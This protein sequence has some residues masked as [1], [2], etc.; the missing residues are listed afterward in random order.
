MTA[1]TPAKPTITA[2]QRRSPTRSPQHRI[3]KR[4]EEERRGEAD[5][6]RLRQ[7]QVAQGG[8]EQQSWRRGEE[9]RA[10]KVGAGNVAVQAG[11]HARHASERQETEALGE[12]AAPGDLDRAEVRGGKLD[13]R[14][15]VASSVIASAMSST[16]RRR[17]EIA[18]ALGGVT[19]GMPDISAGRSQLGR[20]R[21]P[22]GSTEVTAARSG[23]GIWQAIAM[24]RAGGDGAAACTVSQ[25]VAELAR[26]AGV[27]GAPC[28]GGSLR[29][30]LS[31]RD[32]GGASRAPTSGSG[33]AD[34]SASV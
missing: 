10:E 4:G 34:S 21:P 5:H 12:V 1:S 7:R 14:S 18:S 20:G 32:R 8:H 23:S 17:R 25:I 31:G 16:L 26:A 2:S 24:P 29:R 11:R 30:D 6:V 15:M 13:D 9:A 3:G 19:I 28:G 33:I 27:E 22:D